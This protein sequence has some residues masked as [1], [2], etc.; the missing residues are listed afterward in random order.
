MMENGWYHHWVSGALLDNQLWHQALV[1]D[2]V[3]ESL[4]GSEQNSNDAMMWT[5]LQ[6][7]IVNAC[8]ED[9]PWDELTR[10]MRYSA[11]LVGH[12]WGL[13]AGE[14]TRVSPHLLFH[15]PLAD[16][17]GFQRDHLEKEQHQMKRDLAEVKVYA[18]AMADS[19]H[20]RDAYVDKEQDKFFCHLNR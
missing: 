4:W 19:N 2:C 11:V 6:H 9:S 15:I 5:L 1:M 17:W 13:L 10:S 12:L 20:T 8:S 18:K 16:L 3:L 7:G 14:R